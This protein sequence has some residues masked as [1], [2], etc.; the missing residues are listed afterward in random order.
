MLF[1]AIMG[2]SFYDI[3][4]TFMDGGVKGMQCMKKINVM[5]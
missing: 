4:D 1:I 5:S 3:L 2:V